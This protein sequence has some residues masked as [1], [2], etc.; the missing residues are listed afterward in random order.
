MLTRRLDPQQLKDRIVTA[1]EMDRKHHLRPLLLFKGNQTEGRI[2]ALFNLTVAMMD[3]GVDTMTEAIKFGYIEDLRHL[4]GLHASIQGT[5][6]TSILSR[7]HIHKEVADLVPGLWEYVRYLGRR[8]DGNSP[9]GGISALDQIPEY[10]LRVRSSRD[11]RLM[12]DHLRPQR[13]PRKE[14][15]AKVQLPEVYPYIS[16]IPTSDHDMLL[17]VDAIVPKGLPNAIRCDVCQDMIVAV[18]SGETTVDN[19]R[20]DLKKYMGQFWKMFPDKYGHISLDQ[21]VRG[22]EDFKL[23]DRVSNRGVR[24]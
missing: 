13:A 14:R 21:A 7:L 10:V 8:G 6:L 17:A 16:G 4:C 22:T 11:W 19:L 20:G 1:A 5:S 2:R 15:V 18:L 3:T 9:N 24:I 12:P 23:I